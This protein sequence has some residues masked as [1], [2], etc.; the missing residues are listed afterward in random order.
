[1]ATFRTARPARNGKHSSFAESAHNNYNARSP[2]A[3]RPRHADLPLQIA[4]TIRCRTRSD[5]RC[6]RGHHRRSHRR[7]HHPLL[8]GIA[9]IAWLGVGRTIS[10]A[11]AKSSAAA[12]HRHARQSRQRRQNQ[13]PFHDCSLQYKPSSGGGDGD[14]VEQL[15]TTRR[16]VQPQRARFFFATDLPFRNARARNIWYVFPRRHGLSDHAG[17]RAPRLSLVPKVTDFP[18]MRID[19][20]VCGRRALASIALA[21]AL[22]VSPD[23]A[24]DA[25]ATSTPCVQAPTACAPR[26]KDEVWLISTRGLCCPDVEASPPNFQVWQYDRESHQWDASSLDAFL[27]AQ[28]PEMPTVFWIHGN[29]IGLE[30]A[31]D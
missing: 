15:Y 19:R 8:A 10:L 16:D 26:T 22:W 14:W 23:L 20:C 6:W 5:G 12:A 27:A 29:R 13:K 28:T 7:T 25:H 11:S 24:T 1:M 30:D 17:P 3:Y 2:T 4:C 9:A 31:R 18:N 21:L